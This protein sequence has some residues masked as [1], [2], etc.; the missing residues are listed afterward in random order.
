MKQN[1]Y[2]FTLNLTIDRAAMYIFYTICC[3]DN[4]FI[5]FINQ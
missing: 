4:A 1:I 3:F 2:N 5:V